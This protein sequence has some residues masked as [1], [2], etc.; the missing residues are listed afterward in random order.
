[1][2]VLA[3]TFQI[4]GRST[5]ASTLALQVGNP[6]LQHLKLVAQVGDLVGAGEHGALALNANGRFT[7][8]PAANYTGLD[9]FTYRASDGA[10]FSTPVTVTITINGSNDA[11]VITVG[12]SDSARVKAMFKAIQPAPLLLVSEADARNVREIAAQIRGT[13]LDPEARRARSA[14]RGTQAR[15]HDLPRRQGRAA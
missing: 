9:S 2:A 5:S 4:Q 1:M 14:G 6:R 8:T 7:F 13:A 15:R 11:P 10:A 12:G 3:P